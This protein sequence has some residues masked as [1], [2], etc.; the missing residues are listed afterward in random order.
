MHWG[1]A[2]ICP[3]SVAVV[4][5]MGDYVHHH[6]GA[7]KVRVLFARAQKCGCKKVKSSRNM[8]LRKW[9]V[10]IL[11]CSGQ[12]Q[13][14]M[15]YWWGLKYTYKESQ[16]CLNAAQ[17]GHTSKFTNSKVFGVQIVIGISFS[18]KSLTARGLRWIG[19]ELPYWQ[20]HDF[21]LLWSF[22]NQCQSYLLIVSS[23]CFMASCWFPCIWCACAART[24]IF[25]C[26]LTMCF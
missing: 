11:G 7:S 3:C 23:F 9:L 24:S 14:T 15:S 5:N 13:K 20:Y 8:K 17:R 16:K 12:N 2:L 21:A 26:S 25:L 18:R 22:F 4:Y 6:S 1:C 10:F 19:L